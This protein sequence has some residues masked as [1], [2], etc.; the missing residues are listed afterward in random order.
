VVN[1][2]ATGIGAS[3]QTVLNLVEILGPGC[4]VFFDNYFASP[5]LLLALKNRGLPAGCT[6]RSNRTEKCPFKTEKQLRKEGRGSM[7][8]HVS[9]EGILLVKWY[10][11]KEVIVGT[12]H[13]SAE[14]T[15]QVRRWD[16]KNKKYVSI[17]IPALILAY[18]TG[19]GGV[20]RCDQLMSFYRIKTKSVKWYKR[21]LY[22]MLDLTLVN[23]YILYK[24]ITKQ[25]LFEFKLDVAL[26]LMYAERFGNPLA[27]GAV[28]L[29]QAALE[30]G[31]NGD[32][33][34]CEVQDAVRL[35]G[36]N[37][38]PEVVSK[39]GRYCC[40]RGCEKR[41][42]VWCQKCRVYLCLKREQNCFV[43]FHSVA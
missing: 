34:P 10:D 32:P 37:H 4:Q 13:Y 28:L 9:E 15:S 29:H 8:F 17:P 22:H 21:V 14:P 35:D 6:V 23:A 27:P 31:K 39:R 25:P 30:Y 33:N 16:K 43:Y 19:M 3:G 26:A 1:Q 5:G 42:S 40:I 12:N 36:V 11:S 7:D 2:E 38:F 20:D 41:S 24:Q 18:N